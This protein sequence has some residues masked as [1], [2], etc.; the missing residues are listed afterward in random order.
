MCIQ[1]PRPRGPRKGEGGRPREK[2]VLPAGWQLIYKV[3]KMGLKKGTLDRF[4]LTPDG[5]LL[6]TKKQMEAHLCLDSL[7]CLDVAGAAACLDAAESR[8][9]CAGVAK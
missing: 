4:F 8:K 5:T 6:R 7:G 9:V 3:R 1:V 2:K